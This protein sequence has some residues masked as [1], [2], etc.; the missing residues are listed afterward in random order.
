MRF[1]RFHAVRLL[2]ESTL[3]M[4]MKHQV[5]FD[6]LCREAVQLSLD[7]IWSL[8]RNLEVNFLDPFLWLTLT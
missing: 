1:W 6:R 3:T 5:L 4:T 7:L 2:F 8:S